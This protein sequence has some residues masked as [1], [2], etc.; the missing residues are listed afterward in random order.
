MH[1]LFRSSALVLVQEIV[2][3]IDKSRNLFDE[4]E[5]NM[6]KFA[7]I[8]LL[9]GL[10]AVPEF[11][12]AIGLV[13]QPIV[14]SNALR[15]QKVQESLT[16][17]NSENQLVLVNFVSE[18]QVKDW[19]KF[20]QEDNEKTAVSSTTIA[21]RTNLKIRAIISIPAD[22][23]NGEYKG[24]LSIIKAADA[25]YT[26][27]ES[28]TS[29]AQKISRSVTIKI[30]DSEILKLAASVIPK[31]FDLLPNEPLSVRIIYDNQSNI[32]LRPSIGFKIVNEEKTVYNAIFPYPESEPDVKSRAI[33]E[34]PALEIPL[35]NVPTGDYQAKLEFMRGDKV[36]LENHFALT[37]GGQKALVS[38]TALGNSD[39][40]SKIMPFFRNNLSWLIV[41]FII[42]VA[43]F[44]GFIFKRKMRL[45]K[46]ET[47]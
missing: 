3:R 27:D 23:A 39:I 34:I 40:S 36:I 6:K 37:I 5:K 20:Y 30:S 31:T 9:L 12:S 22:V 35:S 38:N 10:F 42:L 15:G 33:Y 14:I 21:A 1:K 47:N 18:G 45:G 26:K 41:L 17:V 25:K 44:A 4:G 24:A 32:S 46:V 43:A 28:V 13:T 8:L 7:L 29:I 2:K 16:I 11:V 19:V